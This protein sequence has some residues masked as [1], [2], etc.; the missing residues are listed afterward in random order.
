[1]FIFL[2]TNHA[3]Y[4]VVFLFAIPHRNG[5]ITKKLTTEYGTNNNNQ[6]ERYAYAYTPG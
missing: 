5:S 3:T 2:N 1:M 6:T 4:R